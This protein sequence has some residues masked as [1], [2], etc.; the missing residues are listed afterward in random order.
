MSYAE[1]F[2]LIK[3]VSEKLAL[4]GIRKGDMALTFTPLTVESVVLCWACL[5][6]GVVFVPVDHNWS[7]ELLRIMLRKLPPS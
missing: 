2:E 5:Y 6:T 3:M 4:Q 7:G 1:G